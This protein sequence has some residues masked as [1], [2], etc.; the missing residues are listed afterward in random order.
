MSL[1]SVYDNFAGPHQTLT[2]AAGRPTSP[3]TAGGLCD[4]A[5]TL[6]E[7]AVLPE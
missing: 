3:P 6:T 4:H 5:W 2:K 1:H 7:I